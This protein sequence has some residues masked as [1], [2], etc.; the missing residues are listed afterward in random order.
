M[1]TLVKSNG[2]SPL[3]SRL[4]DFSGTD[5]F[6]NGSVGNE[7]LLAMP[8]IN[9]RESKNNYELEIAVPGFKKEDF[10]ITT[11]NGLIT[12]SAEASTEKKDEKGSYTRK[13]FSRTSFSRTF[14]LPD[15]VV[16]DNIHALY[17]DGLLTVNMEKSL[18]CFTAKKEVIVE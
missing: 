8:P 18:G 15:N 4:E 5:G 12:I 2:T 9:I 6:F 17:Q 10:K 11:E 16:E 13:E 1:S 3:R 14:T 7:V